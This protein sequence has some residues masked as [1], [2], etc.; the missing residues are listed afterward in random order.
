[1]KDSEAAARESAPPIVVDADPDAIA[2]AAS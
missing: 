1:L 2:E